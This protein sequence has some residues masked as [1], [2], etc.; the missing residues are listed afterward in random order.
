MSKALRQLIGWKAGLPTS[1]SSEMEHLGSQNP[2]GISEDAVHWPELETLSLDEPKDLSPTDL[3]RLEDIGEALSQCSE[4][5]FVLPVN[6]GQVSTESV[7]TMPGAVAHEQISRLA[8]EYGDLIRDIKDFRPIR[9]KSKKYANVEALRNAYQ[10][11]EGAVN[12]TAWLRKCIVT[13]YQQR[14]MQVLE[15]KLTL[16]ERE[17]AAWTPLSGKIDQVTAT[18]NGDDGELLTILEAGN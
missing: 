14:Y 16:R 12:L 6:P 13:N 2:N 11:Y 5:K 1:D 7:T 18:L 8:R 3:R 9:A 4:V 17:L 10:R 15:E